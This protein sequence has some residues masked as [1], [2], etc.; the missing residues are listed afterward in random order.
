M[1]DM[2]LFV[3]HQSNT[4]TE[5][6]RFVLLSKDSLGRLRRGLSKKNNKRAVGNKIMATTIVPLETTQKYP[7]LDI[8]AVVQA[9]W[10]D[11]EYR[12][13]KIKNLFPTFI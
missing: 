8:G 6:P 2:V 4:I 11:D 5:C 13:L 3:F 9:R 12:M 10:R 1:E 7:K